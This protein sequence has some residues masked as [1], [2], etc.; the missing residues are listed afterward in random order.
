MISSPRYLG[1][2]RNSGRRDYAFVGPYFC[3]RAIIGRQD[4]PAWGL[5]ARL[6]DVRNRIV[7]H[8]EPG[9]LGELLACNSLVPI[10]L[11]DYRYLNLNYYT[12]PLE[13]LPYL[14]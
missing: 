4:D 2:R 1:H 6:N 13:P 10:I 11:A 7:H 12:G 5:I 3:D 8:L 14:R 9:D